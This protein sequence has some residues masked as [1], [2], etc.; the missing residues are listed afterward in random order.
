MIETLVPVAVGLLVLTAAIHSLLGERRLITPLM[1]ERTGV[2][3]SDQYRLLLR[4]TWHL[5]SALSLAL[6]AVLLA[7]VWRPEAVLR[8]ALTATGTVF[9]LAGLI[10]A[11]GTRLRHIGWPFLTAIGVIAFVALAGLPV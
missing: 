4:L 8:I 3:A 7:A 5:G 6:A 9:L 2:L 11:V 10:D 1:R